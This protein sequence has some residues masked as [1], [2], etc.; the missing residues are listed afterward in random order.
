MG[1]SME[2]LMRMRDINI[3]DL[4]REDLANIEDIVIDTELCIESRIRSFIEQ[5]GNPYAQNIGEYI[6]QVEFVEDTD[7]LIDDRL[8]LLTKRKTDIMI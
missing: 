8:I 6:L 7:D 3:M 2:E 1:V 5:T 4:K